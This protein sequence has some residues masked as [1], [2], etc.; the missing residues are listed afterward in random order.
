M[1]RNLWSI[2][3]WSTVRRPP[4][5]KPEDEDLRRARY[6][7]QD[8]VGRLIKRVALSEEEI[9]ALPNNLLETISSRQFPSNYDAK[10]HL[11]PF[12][13]ADLLDDG[14]PWVCLQS[15]TGSVLT[16]SHAMSLGTASTFIVYIRLPGTRQDTLN[17]VKEL[18]EFTEA[19]VFEKSG[20]R[21][22]PKTPQ[23]PVGT[24]FALIERP[25]LISDQREI[26]LSPLV[27]TVQ[28]RAYL[29]LAV[30]PSFGVSQAVTEFV[31]QPR[32]L[33]Q[34]KPAMRPHERD[35]TYF[36]KFFTR[37]PFRGSE[38]PVRQ[39][40][41]PLQTCMTCH[42]AAGVASFNSRGV[43]SQ[44]PQL[45]TKLRQGTPQG[46]A[47]LTRVKKQQEYAWGLLEARWRDS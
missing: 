26:V 22:N 11:K 47:I 40:Q 13:P 12:L 37:D 1:Q 20:I 41:N 10:D 34:G 36:S 29:N 3:D 6:T 44:V 35:E 14:G 18:S 27:Y 16:K 45:P 33:M 19:L 9:L 31:L 17:Y 32:A 39:I 28:L 2:F 8:K 43:I 42:G 30:G 38:S 24:Q 5:F 23:F 46:A 4:T 15:T 21:L 7:I 25:F